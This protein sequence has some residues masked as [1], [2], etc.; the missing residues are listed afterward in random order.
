MFL[1]FFH[2]LKVFGIPVT[3]KEYLDMLKGL[4]KG[5]CSN[6]NIQEF[7]YFSRLSLVK[8]EKYYD[9]FDKAFK[10]F[11][12]YNK[13]FISEIKSKYLKTG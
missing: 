13:E 10:S 9:R 6:N 7:Y 8:D 5:I 12:E 1:K 2:T 11:Y 3:I 4:D